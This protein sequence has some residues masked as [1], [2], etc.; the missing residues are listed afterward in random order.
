MD[1]FERFG[2]PAPATS[3]LDT[4]EDDF[5]TERRYRRATMEIMVTAGCGLGVV[6]FGLFAALDASIR[7]AEEFVR[8]GSLRQVLAPY[9][10][11]GLLAPLL[12]WAIGWLGD[13]RGAQTLLPASMGCALAALVGFALSFTVFH[14]L[15]ASAKYVFL[16]V[17]VLMVAAAAFRDNL[18]Q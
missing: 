2:E 9:V 18:T 6:Y 13:R 7:A 3:H 15:P 4:P 14:P 16:G 1:D 8:T 5:E 17:L 12:G 10:L 11:F